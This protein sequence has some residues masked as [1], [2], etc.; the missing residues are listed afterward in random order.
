MYIEKKETVIQ[1][2]QYFKNRKSDTRQEKEKGGQE[3]VSCGTSVISKIKHYKKD[4]R[5]N[6]SINDYIF[7][8][9]A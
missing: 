7:R 8:L 1:R 4:T 6:Q 5:K 9:N 2:F 3:C